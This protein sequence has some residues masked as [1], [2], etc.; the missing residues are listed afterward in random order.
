[1]NIKNFEDYISKPVFVKA[2]AYYHKGWVID[3][4]KGEEGKWSALVKDKQVYEV[5]ITLK[6]QYDIIYVHCN[7]RNK[8]QMCGHV[9]AVLYEIDEEIIFGDEEEEEEPYS[10]EMKQLIYQ[11]PEKELREYIL[12]YASR[13]QSFRNDLSIDFSDYLPEDI[14]PK[15]IRMVSEL[16]E[17]ATDSFGFIDIDDADEVITGI[18]N[19]FAK[20]EEHLEKK[21]PGEA[22]A[23]VS[24]IAPECMEYIESEDDLKEIGNPV[25]S[26]FDIIGRILNSNPRSELKKEIFDWLIDLAKQNFP[27]YYEE[28]PEE[29]LVRHATTKE[30]IRKVLQLLD[31][32]L[33]ALPEKQDWF[34]KHKKEMY[35]Y[36]KTQLYERT[37]EQEKADRIINDNLN[38]IEFRERIVDREI[39]KGNLQKAIDL[40]EQG[41]QIARQQDIRGVVTEW[42][43]RLLSLYQRLNDSNNTRK[44]AFELFLNTLFNP[45]E[46]YEIYKQTFSAA[47][48][49]E[50]KYNVIK[51]LEKEDE[52][53]PE[54]GPSGY[55]LLPM[56]YIEEGMWNRLIMWMK[57]SPNIYVLNEYL[58]YLREKYPEDLL[59]LFREAILVEARRASKRNEYRNLTAFLD[60]MGTIPGGKEETKK[61]A[62]ELMQ[63][64][65]NR[66]AMKDELRNAGYL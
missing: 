53:P 43:D 5:Q 31:E 61:L 33:K 10:E 7:C 66:P 62:G 8:N 49:S 64:Y 52:D 40:T 15:Y 22:F 6:D 28:Y 18:E 30:H 36:L 32:Q 35:L 44:L 34:S 58:P 65:S 27:D 57:Q 25:Q 41:I 37:G 2:K 21:N 13:D 9:A 16:F 3:L 45:M 63:K 29:L 20:A 55:P 56:A 50:E 1:M 12:E 39:E 48:W 42:K 51:K 17:D 23:I 47:E 24:A 4:T 59:Y 60:K 19:L 54:F 46:Y 14:Q 38:I 26:A 11:I